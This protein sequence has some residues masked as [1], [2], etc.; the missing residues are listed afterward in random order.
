MMQ[1]LSRESEEWMR[2]QARRY[3]AS[4]VAWQTGLSGFCFSEAGKRGKNA[5][6][7]SGHP[8]GG[9]SIEPL[10]HL[11]NFRVFSRDNLL[12]VIPAETVWPSCRLRCLLCKKDR[13]CD[14][15]CVPCQR[16]L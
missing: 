1:N 11:R 3:C 16:L 4:P 8:R 10:Q 14:D 13:H 6:T 15:L 9:D 2:I 7:R 5:C 12:H